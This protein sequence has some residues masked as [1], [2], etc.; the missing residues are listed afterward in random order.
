MVLDNDDSQLRHNSIMNGSIIIILLH[1]IFHILRRTLFGQQLIYFILEHRNVL[2]YHEII[3]K[4]RKVVHK[5]KIDYLV[6]R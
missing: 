6:C 4:W 2:L 1:E 5:W 3:S